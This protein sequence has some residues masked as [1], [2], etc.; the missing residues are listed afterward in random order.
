[1]GGVVGVWRESTLVLLRAEVGGVG[2]AL[3]GGFPVRPKRGRGAAEMEA[4]IGGVGIG[5]GVGRTGDVGA[6]GCAEG[7]GSDGNGRRGELEG[8]FLGGR[9]GRG[10]TGGVG[11][12]GGGA[13]TS[14]GPRLGDGVGAAD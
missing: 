8:A 12:F 11:R 5:E 1:M 13:G 14:S 10:F 7:T 3:R 9:G 4:S 2:Y 6:K